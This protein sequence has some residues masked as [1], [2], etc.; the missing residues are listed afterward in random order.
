MGTGRAD[1]ERPL[2]LSLGGQISAP[3]PLRTGVSNRTKGIATRVNT[4]GRGRKAWTLPGIGP[5][6]RGHL[7]FG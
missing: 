6:A 2:P 3:R 4:I 5:S 1:L 7:V